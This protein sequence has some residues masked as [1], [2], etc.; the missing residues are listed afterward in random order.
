MAIGQFKC[1][2]AAEQALRDHS[3][4]VLSLKGLKQKGF[5]TIEDSV[6]TPR[7]T[8]VTKSSNWNKH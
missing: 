7:T 5:Q 3:E 4:V 8:E 1:N 6:A 2:V